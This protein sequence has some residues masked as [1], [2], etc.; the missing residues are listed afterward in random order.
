MLF[1]VVAEQFLAAVGGPHGR[2]GI[3]GGL[4]RIEDWYVGDGWYTDG[5]GPEL[6][7]LR[8][9]AMHLYPVLWARMA[10]DAARPE[11]YQRAAAARSSASTSTCS[12][13]T[14]RP[15]TRAAP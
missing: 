3:D 2:R 12:A 13:P 7:L 8:G 9:W 10:G 1:Q 5:D 15:C 11:R 14:A 6:R 4:E